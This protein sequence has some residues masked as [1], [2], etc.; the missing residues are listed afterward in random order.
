MRQVRLERAGE[1]RPAVVY[2][3]FGERLR[4][5]MGRR[6]FPSGLAA[7]LFPHTAAIH[8][9]WMRFAI[10]V[11]YLDREGRVLRVTPAMGPW[12]L[13]PWVQGAWWTVEAPAGTL[14][15]WRP[16]D[17]VRIRPDAVTAGG[18]GPGR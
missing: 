3:A 6:R 14:A 17:R 15:D 10:D 1:S 8:T 9:C 2:E 11:A 7:V 18:S 13:G 4:G 12:R 16:G 5:L